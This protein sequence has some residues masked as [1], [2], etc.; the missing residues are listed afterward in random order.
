MKV[1]E[2]DLRSIKALKMVLNKS[3]LEIEGQAVKTVASLLL[4]F[5]SVELRIEESLKNQ[6]L[7]PQEKKEVIKKMGK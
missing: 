2:N 3:K 5:D 1:D 6:P 4:W 7:K